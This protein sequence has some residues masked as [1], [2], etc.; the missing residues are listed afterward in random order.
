MNEI[1]QGDVMLIPVNVMPPQD[2]VPVSKVILADGELTGHSHK[3]TAEHG[4]VEWVD[5]NLDRMIWVVGP[6][7]G[8]LH[9]EDHDPIPVDVVQ[10]ETAYR[11]VIQRELDL[12]GQWKQVVD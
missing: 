4:V 7:L 1:R 12:S 6:E 8:T 11:V 2:K 5:S 9:H 3:L 10:P